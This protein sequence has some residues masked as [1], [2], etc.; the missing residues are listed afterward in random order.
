MGDLFDTIHAER[1]GGPL[2]SGDIFDQIHSQNQQEESKT[3]PA[4]GH[5]TQ[6]MTPEEE[7][8]AASFGH[9]M[10]GS[11]GDYLGT[12]GRVLSGP[13]AGVLNAPREIAD[14]AA[15]GFHNPPSGGYSQ[16]EPVSQALGAAT[17]AVGPE[18][19]KAAPTALKGAAKGAISEA[20]TMVPLRRYG[21]PISVPKPVATAAAGG[22]AARLMGLPHEAGAIVGGAAP[23]VT[24]AFRGAK[25][26]LLDRFAAAAKSLK[27]ETAA[28]APSEAASHVD[29]SYKPGNPDFD[30]AQAAIDKSRQAS[31]PAKSVEQTLQ[32]E[33]AAKRA[34]SATPAAPETPKVDPMLEGLAQ[35]Q[36]GKPFARATESEQALIRNIAARLDQPVPEEPATPLPARPVA[37]QPPA[38]PAAPGKTIQQILQEE[39]AAKRAAA[40]AKE[41]VPAQ[42]QAA[43]QLE[44]PR[45]R[46]AANG[47]L[48]SP[49][50]RAAEITAE[51]TR[52]KAQRFAQALHGYVSSAELKLIPKGKVSPAEI[53]KGA[54]PGWGNIT[55]DLI[56]RG[57]LEKGEMPPN[58]SIPQIASELQKLEAA[59]NQAKLR[60]GSAR[61]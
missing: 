5:A 61:Q 44:A 46:Y 30:A 47:E 7:A 35:G 60:S 42:E 55:E 54:L 36:L 56:G 52:Q 12:A 3:R 32:E 38:E 22:A 24:G 43:P 13:I 16:E 28:E 34:Q 53:S 6:R 18:A 2:P 40:P 25:A 37:A 57:L 1:A 59:A 29:P 33:M 11:I 14:W 48:K 21:I 10:T 19:A 27:P 23:I 39:M 9:S 31:P 41:A 58:S 50:L 49:Q 4:T 17:M 20:T 26:A 51:N 15:R 45:S 8:Q